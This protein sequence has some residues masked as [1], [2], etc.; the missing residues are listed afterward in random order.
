MSGHEQPAPHRALSGSVLAQRAETKSRTGKGERPLGTLLAGKSC[1]P[2]IQLVARRVAS[3][4]G[5][6][7][8]EVAGDRWATRLAWARKKG[9]GDV[10]SVLVGGSRGQS[11]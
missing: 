9:H 8:P 2:S 3:R 10:E 6:A 4:L 1:S 11:P 5:V 7:D